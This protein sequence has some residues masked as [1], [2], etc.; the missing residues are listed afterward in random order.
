MTNIKKCVNIKN[1]RVLYANFILKEKSV[2]SYQTFDSTLGVPERTELY[3]LV[4]LSSNEDQAI[5]ICVCKKHGVCSHVE[6][7]TVNDID[8]RVLDFPQVGELFVSEEAESLYNF[9]RKSA[10]DFRECG[11]SIDTYA[12]RWEQNAQEAEDAGEY[13]YPGD[14]GYEDDIF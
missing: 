10:E 4:M 1:M 11:E 8:T 2:M 3:T 9:I 13:N 12:E 14:D 5:D 7:I 6:T